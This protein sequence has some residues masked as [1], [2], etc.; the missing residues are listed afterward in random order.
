MWSD[1]C[2]SDL[3]KQEKL[4]L[5]YITIVQN[6]T[7]WFGNLLTVHKTKTESSHEFLEGMWY[8]MQSSFVRLHVL[9]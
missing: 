6:L 5:V 7:E 2:N 4:S 8:S 3:S 1:K 9:F